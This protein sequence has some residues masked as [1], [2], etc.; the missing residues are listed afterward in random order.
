MKISA[1][2]CLYTHSCSIEDAYS[3]KIWYKD[4]REGFWE[5]IEASF[6]KID[7]DF[8][9]YGYLKKKNLGFLCKLFVQLPV[10][11]E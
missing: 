7:L 10:T 9:V 3:L 2:V 5:I 8:L 11:F 1:L 6:S 4:A